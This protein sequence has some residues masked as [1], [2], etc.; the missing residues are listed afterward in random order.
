MA[1]SIKIQ[2]KNRP[3]LLKK[4]RQLP[5]DVKSEVSKAVQV[6]LINI[7]RNA[8]R[9]LRVGYGYKTGNLK[10]NIRFDFKKSSLSGRVYAP[11]NIA[12]YAP[13]VE[14]G[15]GTG[16]SLTKGV[17][18]AYAATFKGAGKRRRNYP[19]R[20]FL[21]PALFSERKTFINNIK[22]SIKFANTK[23]KR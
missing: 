22:K 3:Q 4:L 10:R 1:K 9:V 14:F 2:F 18:S 17:S 21:Y 16:V 19:A 15:T 7:Q 5:E 12:P 23:F 6:S 13:Y 8:Q 20:P 11:S